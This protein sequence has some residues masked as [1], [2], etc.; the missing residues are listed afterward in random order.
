MWMSCV[1]VLLVLCASM[2]GSRSDACGTIL[3]EHVLAPLALPWVALLITH[4]PTVLLASRERTHHLCSATAHVLVVW[5][6]GGGV[7]WIYKWSPPVAY[8][9][10]LHSSALLLGY[11]SDPGVVLGRRVDCCLRGVCT[12]LLVIGAWQ[13]GPALPVVDLPRAP[14]G[15]SAAAFAHLVGFLAPALLVPPFRAVAELLCLSAKG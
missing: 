10:A 8:A 9:L 7:A 2:A 1:T 12:G 5:G 13:L 4:V 15:S 11:P 14:H 6:A 3:P